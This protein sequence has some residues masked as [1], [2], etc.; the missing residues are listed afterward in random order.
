MA[1][2]DPGEATSHSGHVI[3]PSTKQK[4][5][6]ELGAITKKADSRVK[7]KKA[8]KSKGNS[9]ATSNNASVTSTGNP[10]CPSTPVPAEKSNTLAIVEIEDSDS[11]ES[12]SEDD[13]AKLGQF[14]YYL[15]KGG[16]LAL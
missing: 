4:A 14:C 1:D 5:L 10:T 6:D 2:K 9:L 13:E 16:Y 12:S 3:K 7:N 15:F 11:T 8:K